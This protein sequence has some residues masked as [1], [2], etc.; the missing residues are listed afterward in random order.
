MQ[1]YF[2]SRGLA[3]LWKIS[4]SKQIKDIL[5]FDK[6]G[7]YKVWTDLSRFRQPFCFS[8]VTLAHNNWDMGGFRELLYPQSPL[9]TSLRPLWT[10][11]ALCQVSLLPCSGTRVV[12]SHPLQNICRSA[13]KNYV[14]LY[15]VLMHFEHRVS[16]QETLSGFY[17]FLGYAY[18]QSNSFQGICTNIQGHS[19]NLHVNFEVVFRIWYRY[20]Y[21]GI[22][23]LVQF[24]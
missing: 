12:D 14:L 9:M 6:E 8:R 13:C 18:N 17:F 22:A 23:M 24:F 7:I 3:L 16:F 21:V 4:L 2:R 20:C 5:W 1:A 19:P 15:Y 10:G 11:N